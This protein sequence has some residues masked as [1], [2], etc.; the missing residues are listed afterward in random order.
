MAPFISVGIF[1]L[2]LRY[3]RQTP[4][5]WNR[6]Y[7]CGTQRGIIEPQLLLLSTFLPLPSQRFNITF[8]SLSCHPDKGGKVTSISCSAALH[9]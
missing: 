8:L 1:V 6:V 3:W 7:L 9:P 5:R 4:F 2:W